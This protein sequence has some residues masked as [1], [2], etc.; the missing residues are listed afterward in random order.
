MHVHADMETNKQIYDCEFYDDCYLRCKNQSI[1][2]KK[3]TLP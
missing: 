1:V 2:K 3:L